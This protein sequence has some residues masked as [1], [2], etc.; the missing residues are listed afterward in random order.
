[1][2]MPNECYEYA[3]TINSLA[4]QGGLERREIHEGV[5]D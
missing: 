3:K 1:M 4:K 5:D 2:K